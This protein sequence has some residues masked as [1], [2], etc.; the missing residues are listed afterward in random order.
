MSLN[1]RCPACET[2]FKVVPDQLR[3]SSG[4]VR[5]GRC[6]EVFDAATHM[7]P[8]AGMQVQS[9]AATFPE[10][11]IPKLAPKSEPKPTLPPPAYKPAAPVISQPD[12]KP[13]EIPELSFVREA[14]NKAFWQQ[15][16]VLRAMLALVVGLTGLMAL[17]IIVDQRNLLAAKYPATQPSFE[18]FC[19]VLNCVVEP[20]KQIDALKI[21]SS[22]F[23]KTQESALGDT[24]GLK[25]TL[26]NTAT[27]PLAPPAFEL[28]LTNVNDKAVIRRVLTAQDMGFQGK[29]LAMQ[30]EWSGA[31]SLF[32]SANSAQSNS[33]TPITGYRLLAFYP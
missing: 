15:T 5:C 29:T 33:R 7:L 28:S 27:L 19:T 22:T 4:W 3:V 8:P 13:H 10:S 26:K 25:V 1:T 21:E 11:F 23:Q 9:L 32:V 14:K 2:V 30:G 17:Q 24:F 12:I 20:V 18:S 6:A 31:L 16:Y